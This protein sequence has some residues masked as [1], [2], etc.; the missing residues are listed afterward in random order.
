MLY[1]TP[2]LVSPLVVGYL[3]TLMLSPVYGPIN[4]L[5]EGLGADALARPWLGDPNT[6]L[7]SVILINAWQWAGFPMLI[8]GAALGGI[9]QD[10]VDAAR[11]DGAGRWGA[12]R[13]VTF[14]LLTPAVGVVTIL[15]FI[16]AFNVF[17]LIY[18][19]GGST[20]GPGGAFDM[21]VPLFYRLAFGGGTN[22]IGVS[23]ALAVM[24]FVMVFGGSLLMDRALRRREARLS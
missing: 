16:G 15:S 3:W 1:S 11:I 20:G 7:L 5:F 22:A 14:P 10:Y 21:V 6:A 23:S 4:G 2:Y 24:L 12:F 19:L 17:D 9:S 13:Y 8:F 18:A